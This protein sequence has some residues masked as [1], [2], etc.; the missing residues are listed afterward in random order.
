MTK[1]KSSWFWK[2]DIGLRVE[3]AWLLP[4]IENLSYVAGFF[5]SSEKWAEGFSHNQSRGPTPNSWPGFRVLP[6]GWDGL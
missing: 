2:C 1:A 5:P 3:S 4:L 6:R